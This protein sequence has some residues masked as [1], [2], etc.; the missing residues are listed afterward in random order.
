MVCI[1]LGCRLI[2]LGGGFGLLSGLMSGL[3]GI[4]VTV[5]SRAARGMQ[6]RFVTT[7]VKVITSEST[8]TAISPAAITYSNFNSKTE[9]KIRNH[10]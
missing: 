8:T 4:G 1:S 7:T 6:V 3:Y 2:G 10:R 9:N 5:L